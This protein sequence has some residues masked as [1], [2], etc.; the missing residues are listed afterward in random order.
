[1]AEAQPVQQEAQPSVEKHTL[2]DCKSHNREE[3]CWL[4]ISG[5][6]YDVTEFLDEHPGGFDIVLAACG[7][8]WH[9]LNSSGKEPAPS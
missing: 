1:M 4:V 9:L 7:K 3:D 6:V 5:K 8:T 2:E